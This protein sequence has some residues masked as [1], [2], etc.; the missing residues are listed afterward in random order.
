MQW[1]G[2]TQSFAML[3]FTDV[4]IQVSKGLRMIATLAEL[5]SFACDL[6]EGRTTAV[7]VLT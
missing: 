5:G 2:I 3:L 4:S 7:T 1:R 6:G